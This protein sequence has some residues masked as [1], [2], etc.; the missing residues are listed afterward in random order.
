M[1]MKQQ[2]RLWWFIIFASVITAVSTHEQLLHKAW[3]NI[4][5][6]AE[7]IIELVSMI[8][9]IVAGIMRIS[10]ISVDKET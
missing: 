2:S 3:P 5:D 7:G 8:T 6:Q 4:S 10:P 9:G 1:K